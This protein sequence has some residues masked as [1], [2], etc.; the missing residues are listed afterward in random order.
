MVKHVAEVFA[1]V[2]ENMDS[3]GNYVIW[4][5]QDGCDSTAYG[6]SVKNRREW[7]FQVH[8]EINDESTIS[9]IRCSC[10]KLERDGIPCGHIFCVLKVLR[11]E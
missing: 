3:V 2:K 8:C 7:K 9:L 5:I 10:R 11:A 6:I 1:L 4:D